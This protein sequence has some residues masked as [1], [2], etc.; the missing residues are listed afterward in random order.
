MKEKGKT[1]DPAKQENIEIQG[2][3]RTLGCRKE[4]RPELTDHF[5]VVT[6]AGLGG[7]IIRNRIY[8]IPQRL[9][10]GGVVESI[11]KTTKQAQEKVIGF[12][13]KRRAGELAAGGPSDK[14][15]V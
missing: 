9:S 12:A 13:D 8:L 3:L 10:C 1:I 5:K 7:K 11:S 2:M 6:C 4:D 14:Q 15:N